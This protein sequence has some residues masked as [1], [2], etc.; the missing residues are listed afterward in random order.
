[1]IRSIKGMLSR[2]YKKFK[3]QR[4]DWL[5]RQAARKKRAER[6]RKRRKAKKGRK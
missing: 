6:R 5:K 1:M 2:H 3:K 4:A